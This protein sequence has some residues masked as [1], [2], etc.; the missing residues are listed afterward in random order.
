MLPVHKSALTVYSDIEIVDTYNARTRGSGVEGENDK[1][2]IHHEN[3]MKNLKGKTK[4]GAGNASQKAQN[5]STM[6]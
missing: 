4:M 5:V 1:Y 3:K 6:P 2:E